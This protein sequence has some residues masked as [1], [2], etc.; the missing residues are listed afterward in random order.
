[1]CLA[2]VLGLAAC[3]SSSDTEPDAAAADGAAPGADAAET[4]SSGAGLAAGAATLMSG[5]VRVRAAV[6]QVGGFAGAPVRSGDVT[7][8]GGV[9]GTQK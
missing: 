6:G 9:A 8:V 3:G 4:A 2:I 5:G 7:V 1:M